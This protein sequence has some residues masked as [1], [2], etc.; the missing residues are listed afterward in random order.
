MKSQFKRYELKYYIPEKFCPELI[1]YISPYMVID[2]HLRSKGVDSYLVRS[3]YL[4]T[5]NLK[6]YYEKLSGICYREKFR[7]R[8]YNDERSRIFLEIKKKN[9]NVVTKDRECINY[10]DL[11]IILDRYGKDWMNNGKCKKQSNVIMRFLSFIVALQLR[12]M[13]LITYERQAFVGAFDDDIRLTIDRNICCLPG[14]SY[15]L[16]YS[17]QNWIHIGKPCILE[18]KFNDMMP[19]F[20][21]TIISRFNLRL[22]SISKYCLCIERSKS[23]LL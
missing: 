12:P 8:A 23:I 17:G 7:I 21:K 4:D 19:F 22:Q 3:L 20:F 9:N 13:V 14:R 2:P 5:D 11:H 15:D 18:L 16:F 6:F 1:D 10:D